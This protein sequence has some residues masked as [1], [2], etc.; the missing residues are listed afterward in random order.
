MHDLG[1]LSPAE[2]SNKSPRRVGRGIGSGLGKTA[3]KGHK[4]QKARSGASFIAGFEG[5]QNPLYRRIPKRGFTNLRTKKKFNIIKT[6]DLAI[7]ADGDKVTHQTLLAKG[8]LDDSRW[9]IKILSSGDL[10]RKL[11]VEVEKV[12]KGAK[13]MIEGKGGLVKEK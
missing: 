5:G 10:E 4:G 13:S 12:S 3:G 6:S 1:T 11:E 8:L 7:F 2:G 9:P